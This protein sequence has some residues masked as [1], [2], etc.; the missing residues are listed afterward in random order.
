MTSEDANMHRPPFKYELNLNTLLLFVTLILTG[1]G[2]GMAYNALVTG[3]DANAANIE[4]LEGRIVALETTGRVLDNH[5]LRI[6]NVEVSSRD[7]SAALRA[8]ETSLNALASDM[9]VTREILERIEQ[10]QTRRQP[11]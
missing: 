8:V 10:G 1:V 2:W 7:A 9:R 4:R 3:R 6:T 5:E 11:H